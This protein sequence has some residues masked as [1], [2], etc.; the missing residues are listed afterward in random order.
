MSWLIGT[1]AV[2]LVGVLAMALYRERRCNESLRKRLGAAAADLEGMQKACA[3]LA[4]AGVVQRM[5]ADSGPTARGAAERK[6]VTVLF[7]DLVNYSGLS[8]SLEPAVVAHLLNGYFQRMSDAIRDNGGH[9]AKFLGDGVLAHF[10]ALHDDPWQCDDAVR[11]AL[12]MRTAMADYNAELMRDGV[13]RL[14]LGIGIHRGPGL[15][16]F[17]GSRERMD[18]DFI[19]HTVNLAARVEALTRLYAVDILVTE[20]VRAELDRRFVLE[21]MPAQHVKG[22]SEPVV[23]YAVREYSRAP[24]GGA[25]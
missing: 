23:T 12:A 18:Y 10:G 21:A 24:P 6:V 5:I 16:G 22:I 8:E 9:V 25:M 2:I 7:A 15:T 17:I 11:A 20:A 19:G 4:P 1:M 14:A 3:K 13:G